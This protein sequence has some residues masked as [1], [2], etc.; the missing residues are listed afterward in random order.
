METKNQNKTHSKSGYGS[1]KKGSTASF[2]ETV[3]EMEETMES[4]P[5]YYHE[6]REKT[7]ELYEQSKDKILNFIEEKPIT[8]LFIAGGVGLLLSLVIT[9]AASKNKKD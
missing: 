7:A 9:N 6:I 3:D 1:S 4:L 2:Q 5:D 8:S